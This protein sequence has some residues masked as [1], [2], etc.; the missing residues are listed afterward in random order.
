MSNWKKIDNF[1][2]D[3]K[4]LDEILNPLKDKGYDQLILGCTHY[5][6]VKR[7]IEQILNVKCID[8]AIFVIN[9]L[10][11]LMR[12]EN[13]IISIK[14]KRIFNYSSTTLK[15]WEE[16]SIDSLLPFF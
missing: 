6:L 15:D 12:M 13:N 1:D 3:L 5:P 2:N 4:Q 14:N 16:K 9:R 7:E 8:P 11:K 10:K